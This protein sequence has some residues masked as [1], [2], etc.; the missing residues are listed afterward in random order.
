MEPAGGLLLNFGQ[1]GKNVLSQPVVSHGSIESFDIS[2]LLGV[3]RLDK[4]QLDTLFFG[5]GNQS[6]ADIFRAIITTDLFGLAS[7]LDQLIQ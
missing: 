6:S 3:A 2:I 7:P 4:F 1:I 5:P